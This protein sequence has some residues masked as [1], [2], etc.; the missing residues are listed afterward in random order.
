MKT[1]NYYYKSFFLPDVS[2][3]TAGLFDRLVVFFYFFDNCLTFK[4]HL[5]QNVNQYHHHQC[6]VNLCKNSATLKGI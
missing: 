5:P 4:P 3:K 2:R 6:Y 1:H